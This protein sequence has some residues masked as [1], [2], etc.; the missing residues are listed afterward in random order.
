MTEHESGPLP[1]ST[2]SEAHEA[3][4][5][6]N[7][8]LMRREYSKN[9]GHEPVTFINQCVAR[10]CQNPAAVRIGMDGEVPQLLC[11]EHAGAWV[12]PLVKA[13][14]ARARSTFANAVWMVAIWVLAM[15]GLGFIGWHGMRA[16]GWLCFK[17][18]ELL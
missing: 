6:R 18:G 8:R 9:Y 1:V 3:A 4:V 11:H 17:L 13:T 15:T 16:V 7:R 14:E 10:G 5:I 2:H 12:P